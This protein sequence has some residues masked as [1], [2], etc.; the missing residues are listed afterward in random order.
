[1][2]E[3]RA[4]NPD[5]QSSDPN[6][7][8]PGL[9]PSSRPGTHRRP[10]TDLLQGGGQKQC[11]PGPVF[12]RRL[13]VSL[14]SVCGGGCL[15]DFDGDG[16]CD[17]YGPGACG[18]LSTWDYDGF[19]YDLVEIGGRCWFKQDLRTEH[20]RNG[21]SIPEVNSSSEWS[22]AGNNFLGSW[23]TFSGYEYN[24]NVYNW[25]AIID[26]RGLCPAGWHVPSLEEYTA[27]LDSILP[28]IEEEPNLYIGAMTNALLDEQMAGGQN[29]TSFSATATAYRASNGTHFPASTS[30][31]YWT[32]S[33]AA[34]TESWRFSVL[35]G[36]LNNTSSLNSM[37]N[38]ML[39]ESE[40]AS[41]YAVR[42]VKDQ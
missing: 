16:I 3:N 18:G 4:D 40:R 28:T 34:G 35:G 9:G 19:T 21:D 7:P 26:E 32:E 39:S 13:G 38:L 36:F 37:Y 23:S 33:Y 20:Y 17:E 2:P 29:T 30:C 11:P 6:P 31:F 5:S 8:K 24:G 14:G 22:D 42:C 1:M 12:G 27:L 25:H 10:K 15:G 41:G